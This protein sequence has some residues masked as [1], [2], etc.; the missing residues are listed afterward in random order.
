MLHAPRTV[1]T[2]RAAA[3]DRELELLD[4][5]C[6]RLGFRFRGQP[7]RSLGAQHC[8]RRGHIV[9]ERIVGAHFGR[10]AGYRAA[11]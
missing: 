3:S 5:Q 1:R 2:A 10:S 6:P 4:H 9:G 11:I 7:G 8:L